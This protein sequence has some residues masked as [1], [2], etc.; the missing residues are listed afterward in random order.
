MTNAAARD[1]SGVVSAPAVESTPTILC[2]DDEPMV[3]DSLREQFERQLASNYAVE[4]AQ[5]GAEALEII[6]E[7]TKA[8]VAIPVVV[9]DHIM[10]GM[11]GDE[12]LAR[13][14]VRLP[15][16][17]KILLTG[18]AGLEAVG[19][20]I[21]EAALYR[22]VAKPWQREDLA[23]TVR[24]AIRGFE[25]DAK[26][27]AQHAAALRFV[28]YEFLEL[29]GRTD[30]TEV[31]RGDHVQAPVS[32]FYSDLRSYTTL[33]LG[34][35]PAENLRWINN[36]LHAME[37]PI[38]KHHGFVNSVAGDSILALFPDA[39]AV[40]LAAIESL[41]CLEE[42]NR[43][44]VNEGDPPLRVGIGINTGEVLMA[45]LGGT[46]KLMCDV[47]GDPVNLASRIE[48]LTKHLGT[49]L[50]SGQTHA[51]L[52]DPGRYAM[53]YVDRVHVQGRDV[54][55]ELYEVLDGLAAPE[56]DRKLASR[57]RLRDAIQ[58]Y[59]AGDVGVAR[60]AFEALANGDPDD[61]A[62][63]SYL[64]RIY[65]LENAGVPA[66]WDGATRMRQK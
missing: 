43:A 37:A 48:G 29:L 18:Q 41:Q 21:K 44:R 31:R 45:V 12:L 1:D 11:K 63:A 51:A 52:R 25:A 15:E 13:I 47:V 14:H 10:P 42:H 59:Q 6:D 46:D 50:I 24:E 66:G 26:V 62:Y 40:V 38:R 57:D 17:R 56:R 20:A 8:G 61:R 33:V 2:V 5:D 64:A 23:L 28:P 19:R 22:Y 35:T 49:M 7:L 4:V 27:R 9:S 34:R 54:P 58:S 60:R 32:V 30:L 36:Y 65:E 39:D 16:T 3:L 53:R 55:T